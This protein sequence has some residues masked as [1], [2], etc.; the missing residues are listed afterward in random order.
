MEIIVWA[1]LTVVFIVVEI[2]TIQ[3]VSLWLAAGALTTLI[4][5]VL[6][7]IPLVVQSGIFAVSSAVFVIL[8]LPLIRKRMNIKHTATN[9]ELDIGKSAIV[10]EEINPD[11]NSGRVTLNGVDWSAV[12][13]NGSPIGSGSIVTITQVKGAKLVVRLKTG[14]LL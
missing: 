12:S 9:C 7:D 1:V 5:T 11:C 2:F 3:L 10:I 14:D 8:S 6:L 4:C 13:E